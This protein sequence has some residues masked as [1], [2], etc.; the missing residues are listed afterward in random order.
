MATAINKELQS[1]RT[2]VVTSH[3]RRHTSE[4]VSLPYGPFMRT[5]V[6]CYCMLMLPWRRNVGKGG[7]RKYVGRHP[8]VSQ[9]ESM[10]QKMNSKREDE[11]DG[12]TIQQTR[13]WEEAGAG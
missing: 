7:G 2:W 12:Q 4:N 5:A 11:E 13:D 6:Y 1:H 10:R 3:T 9:D 8:C